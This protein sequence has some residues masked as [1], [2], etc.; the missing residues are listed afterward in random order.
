MHLCIKEL[1][2]NFRWSNGLGLCASTAGA[3]GLILVEKE[4]P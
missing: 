2:E 4:D 1:R 3:L